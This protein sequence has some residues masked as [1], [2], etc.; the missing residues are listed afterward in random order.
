MNENNLESE[1]EK[2]ILHPENILKKGKECRS[3]V[4]KYHDI[5]SVGNQLYDYYNKVGIV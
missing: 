3:W 5:K 1:L 2:L 4:E